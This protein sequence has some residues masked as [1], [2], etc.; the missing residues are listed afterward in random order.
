MALGS[1]TVTFPTT[2]ARYATV[3]VEVASGVSVGAF[4]EAFKMAEATSD[5]SV[6][7]HV[8]APMRITCE[9]IDATHFRAHV[10]SDVPLRGDF[11]LRWV[12][13]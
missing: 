4:I 7:A 8:I 11:N 1:T 9:R 2:G 13:R 6:D 5:N 10:L 12:T 3:D